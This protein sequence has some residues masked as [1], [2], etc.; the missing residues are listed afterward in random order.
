M[1]ASNKGCITYGNIVRKNVAKHT[2]CGK[3]QIDAKR[4]DAAYSVGLEE[5]RV[6]WV[7][8]A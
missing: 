7:A 5:S 8:A 4:D 6:S 1:V 3:T 2:I